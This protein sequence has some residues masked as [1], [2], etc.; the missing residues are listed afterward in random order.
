V[1]GLILFLAWPLAEIAGFVLV[2]RQIG[3]WG[4]LGL[5]LAAV[6]FGIGILRW[7]A[8]TGGLSLNGMAGGQ[9]RPTRSS[10]QGL[11]FQAADGMVL[12]LAALLLILPGFVSDIA[13]IPLLI[14]PVRRAI[15]ARLGARFPI[16]QG[17]TPDPSSGAADRS[18][19]VI[20][21]DYVE[22]EDPETA[23]KPQKGASGWTQH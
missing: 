19:E 12:S 22:I 13:A 21:G 8:L 17:R 15:L 2:G 1:K 10:L 20:E 7:Q 11:A 9:M 3:V 18:G 6:A 14:A 16:G 23:R 4:T 5:V